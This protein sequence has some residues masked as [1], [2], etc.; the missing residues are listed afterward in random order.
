[1]VQSKL[2]LPPRPL[3]LTVFP[4]H[5]IHLEISWFGKWSA[6]EGEVGPKGYLEALQLWDKVTL[7]S[8]YFGSISLSHPP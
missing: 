3:P 5:K 8:Q 7:F 4:S 2:Q 6:M 1:M